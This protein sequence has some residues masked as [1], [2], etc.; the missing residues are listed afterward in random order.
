M[1][2]HAVEPTQ[3]KH[4]TVRANGIRQ[5]YVEAGLGPPVIFLHGWPET[6][7]AWRKQIPVLAPHY[8]VIMPDL[9]GYGD[10][11]KPEIGY[12][13][14]NMAMDL[15]AL[16]ESLGIK[17]AAILGHD[18]GARVATRFAKDHPEMI[19]RLGVFDNIPTRV[20]FHQMDAV[21]AKAH[22]FFI[23][24]Q[25]PEGL[26]EALIAGREEIWLRY[27]YSHWCFNPDAL[28]DEEIA[29]YVRA[30]QQA[31]AVHG[32]CNDYRA[33]A[34]DVA[35]DEVD[36]EV[37]IACPT[38]ALWGQDFE[39]VGKMWDVEGI[40]KSMAINLTTVSIPDCGHLPHEEQPEEFNRAILDFL[41]PW[42]G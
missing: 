32:C 40:W 8:R 11:E 15:K 35:Q 5:H 38:L 20:I 6:S 1:P 3:P 27:L 30:Y 19:E 13:K 29:V 7:Y 12:D 9:R 17:R 24:N 16:M 34:V 21:K 25:V 14:R 33:G 31:G 4:G 28:T 39:L 10:T 36:A 2:A 42:R 23:F 18:R 26:P 41:E 37:K 22:W